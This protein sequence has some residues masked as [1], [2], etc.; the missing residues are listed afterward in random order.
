M[1]KTYDLRGRI[2][3]IEDELRDAGDAFH[4]MEIGA[5]ENHLKA[6]RDMIELTLAIIAGPA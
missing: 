6:A 2:A 3:L 4:L 1:V 5:L